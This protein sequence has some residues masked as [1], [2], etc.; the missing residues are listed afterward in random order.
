MIFVYI[1]LVIL[2][3]ELGIIILNQGVLI[4][5]IREVLETKKDYE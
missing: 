5:D 2:A 4:D 3:I 1:L